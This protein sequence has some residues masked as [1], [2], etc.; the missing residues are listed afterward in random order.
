MTFFNPSTFGP[1]A[2]QKNKVLYHDDF[3]KKR[4]LKISN[5]KFIKLILLPLC[6]VLLSK[7]APL[8]CKT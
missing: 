6:I 1:I 5:C 8:E 2:K 3:S 4:T 7:N